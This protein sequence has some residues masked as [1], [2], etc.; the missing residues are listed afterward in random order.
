MK[1][2]PTQA[3]APRYLFLAATGFETVLS[4]RTRRLAETLAGRGDQVVFAELPTL[5]NALHAR[6]RFG[7]TAGGRPNLKVL[8][9]PPLPWRL[10]AGQAHLNRLWTQRARR[11]LT[12]C[13]GD[14]RDTVV[15][16]STPW[17]CDLLEG[18]PVRVCCYDYLDHIS[19]QAGP[20]RGQVMAQWDRRLL[21]RCDLAFAVSQPLCDYLNSHMASG[22]VHFIP[23]GVADEWIYTPVAPADRAG[24]TGR[25]GRAIAGFVG[26]LF[27]WLDQDLLAAAARSANDIEFVLIG[28]RRRGVNLERLAG[29]DNI[30]IRPAIPLDR[31]PAVLKA[32]DVALIPF[33]RD[34]VSVSAD[35]LKLYE[36]CAL[37]RPVVS[38]VRFRE[39]EEDVPIA[40]AADAG[41]FASAI[42]VAIETDTPHARQERIEYARRHTWSRRCDAV[43]AAI[44][45]CL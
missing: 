4:G 35:P 28:P 20:G 7:L 25:P 27:E 13:L 8:R 22:R 2:V 5:R 19:V 9:F 3:S 12:R 38:T 21:Q 23:N 45:D 41:S 36:Y 14:L 29:V 39:D 15:I 34:I 6:G 17:W 10:R 30:T 40:V 43:L 24:L 33:K 42:R 31:V 11:M 1:S 26:A 37:G 16:C 44:K 32:F 18:L